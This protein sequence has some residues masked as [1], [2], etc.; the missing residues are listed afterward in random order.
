MSDL[1]SIA[2]CIELQ[3][4]LVLMVSWPL[5]TLI[6]ARLFFS[7]V[8]TTRNLVQNLLHHSLL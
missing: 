8:L 5:W 4:A 6:E 1:L 3:V 7:D 2:Y